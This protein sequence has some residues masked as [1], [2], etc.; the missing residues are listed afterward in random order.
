M[1]FNINFSSL[2]YAIQYFVYFILTKLRF[3]IF[4]LLNANKA[5]I[6]T[7]ILLTSYPPRFKILNQVVQN[8]LSQSVSVD[9][10]I[11]IYQN[12]MEL[13]NTVCKKIINYSNVWYIKFLT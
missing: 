12:D 1:S 10:Y 3:K 11:T 4:N 9:I 5:E 2:K 6:Q 13:F 8:L 7:C